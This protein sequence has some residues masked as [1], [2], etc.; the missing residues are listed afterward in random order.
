MAKPDSQNE[1]TSTLHLGLRSVV[2]DSPAGLIQDFLAQATEQEREIVE[3]ALSSDGKSAMVIIHRGPQKGARFLITSEG[4][5]IGRSPE[6]AIF[7]DDVT[8]SRKHAVIEPSTDGAT[9]SFTFKDSGSLNGS[10]I[11]N[12]SITEKKLVAGDEIQI[13][14]YHLLFI[15]AVKTADSVGEK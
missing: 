11:N 1:L 7:L 6:S 13:G 2:G 8:V 4:V 12:D 10:Y 5:T 15:T 9:L 14:K 3:S